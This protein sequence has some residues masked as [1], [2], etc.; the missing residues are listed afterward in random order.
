MD[1]SLALLLLSA[2]QTASALDVGVVGLFTNKAVLVIDGGEP[3]TLSVGST[4]TEGV[5]LLAVADGVATVEVGGK[6]QH[7]KFGEHAYSQGGSSS[8]KEEVTLTADGR[9]QFMTQGSINGV[10]VRFMVDTG[11]TLVAMGPAEATRLGI[12]YRGKGKAGLAQTANGVAPAWRVKLNS[13][14][15]GNVTL[16]NVDGQVGT[17]EMPFILLGMSFL[18]QMDT[19]QEGDKMTLKRRF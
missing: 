6:R 4:T 15:V 13:V 11:A 2:A 10:S 3:R 9:G 7:L 19:R 1:C 18:S 16:T 17:Q 8:G 12:D 5:K 14:K